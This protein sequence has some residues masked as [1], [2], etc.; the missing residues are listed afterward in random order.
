LREEGGGAARK[1]DGQE[2]SEQRAAGNMWETVGHA[3]IL[4]AGEGENCVGRIILS[5]V[6]LRFQ[7]GETLLKVFEVFRVDSDTS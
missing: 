4:T 2:Q 6:L 7:V 5:V 1:E 3:V